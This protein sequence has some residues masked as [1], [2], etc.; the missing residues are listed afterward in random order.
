MPMAKK[1]HVRHVRQTP[2]TA[3]RA[4]VALGG[5]WQAAITEKSTP[6]PATLPGRFIP[7]Q[8]KAAERFFCLEILE[9]DD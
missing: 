7:N 1:T 3:P 2:P 4:S 9:E 8:K 5:G 6:V